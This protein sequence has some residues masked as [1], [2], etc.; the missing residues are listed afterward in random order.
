[1]CS[2][3]LGHFSNSRFG[4]IA[5]SID[6]ERAQIANLEKAI[7]LSEYLPLTFMLTDWDGVRLILRS[8]NLRCSHGSTNTRT[9]LQPA[10]PSTP[11]Q[12]PTLHYRTFN[13]CLDHENLR[14]RRVCRSIS[15]FLHLRTYFVFRGCC[16][17]RWLGLLG[18]LRKDHVYLG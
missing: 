9:R 13:P 12:T 6:D 1:M 18:S 7:Y 11:T 10:G 4:L 15:H 5:G 14:A 8:A 17:R 2:A 16:R 3:I